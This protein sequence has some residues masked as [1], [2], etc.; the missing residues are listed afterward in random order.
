[1]KKIRPPQTAAGAGA[2]RLQTE[3]GIV[4]SM[5]GN[6]FG[7]FGWPTVARMDDA[8]LVV[9]ASGMRLG[10]VCPYGR[11]VFL[12][13]QDEG[14][15]WSSP[16]VINDTPLDDR[17][18]GILSLGGKRLLLSWFTA[19]PRAQILK[20]KTRDDKAVSPLSKKDRVGLAMRARAWA[21]IEPLWEAG[22][23]WTTDENAT[24]FEGSWIRVSD[25]GGDTW[26]PPARV[27]LSAPHGP[28]R[29]RDGK[30]LYFGK[31]AETRA[32]FAGAGEIRAI[33][34]R[35][36][37]RWTSLGR[38]PIY[39]GT[40]LSN[41]HEPHAVELPSGRIIGLIRFQSV[42]GHDLSP[43]GLPPWGIAQTE[44]DDGGKSWTT[45]HSLGFHGSP[46]HLLRHSSGVLICSY[47]Y[48]ANPLGQRVALSHDEGRRWKHDYVLRGDGL[49]ADLGYPSTVEMAD[50]KL[51]TVY[52]QQRAK[53]EHP[54]LLYTH[55]RLP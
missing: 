9:V 47:G 3:H 40:H 16:R 13:S 8:A 54:S 55:W 6:P 41:Y 24:R 37:A 28:V 33:T 18:A 2:K 32:L 30:L 23:Q 46:P 10:H 53:G 17:D 1:M 4:W 52:Y 43:L 26:N 5:P 15:T 49:S 31:S 11:T 27:A 45:A 48:R 42:T 36:G 12:K 38:A 44:S 51:L 35:D 20:P 14:R 29:L 50:G 22:L 7:Y 39:P 21:D 19:D 25:D 34:S